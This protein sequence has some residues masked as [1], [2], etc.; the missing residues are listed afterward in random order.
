MNTY[1]RA[2]L[3]AISNEGVIKSSDDNVVPQPADVVFDVV[4]SN[5]VE[6]RFEENP[7]EE[8]EFEEKLSEVSN[9]SVGKEATDSPTH[10]H[11]S[12]GFNYH[13]ADTSRTKMSNGQANQQLFMYDGVHVLD[14]NEAVD[15]TRKIVV[16]DDTVKLEDL[17]KENVHFLLEVPR[18][19]TI[20][21][22]IQS[23]GYVCVTGIEELSAL[24]K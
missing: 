4:L 8:K 6:K 15:K 22:Y 24:T 5:G 18:M 12:V 14:H 10:R 2:L 1:Q 7:E 17:K 3:Q 9:E 16:I 19:E 20:Q 23:K 11:Y 13:R 21:E